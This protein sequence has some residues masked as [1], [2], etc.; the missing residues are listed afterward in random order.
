MDTLNINQKIAASKKTNETRLQRMTCRNEHLNKLR[1]ETKA[2]IIDDLKPTSL[3]YKDTV[4]LLI[5]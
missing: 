3:I 4:K 2:R 1:D 5:V